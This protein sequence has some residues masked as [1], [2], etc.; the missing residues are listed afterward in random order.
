[1]KI[2]DYLEKLT[3]RALTIGILLSVAGCATTI[4]R[5]GA[6]AFSTGVIAARAQTKTAFDTVVTLTRETALDFAITQERLSEESLEAVP[7]AAAV[8]AWNG[9]FDPIEAYAQRLSSLIAADSTKS[10]E[11]SIG[12]LAKQFNTTS[13]KVK[14]NTGFGNAGQITAGS[15]SV[16]AEVAS[17]L[18]RARAEKEAMGVASKTDP[19][20]RLMFTALAE[21]IG[22]D[23]ISPGLRAT[24][25]ANWNQRVGEQKVKFLEAG[26][27]DKRR[28]VVK[29]YIELLNKR[30]AQD[31][32][33]AALRRTYLSL[34]DAHSALATGH[35]SD[36]GGAIDFI[37][38]ELKHARELKDQFTKTLTK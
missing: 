8:A 33:L 34:A 27:P 12:A 22:K 26:T 17:A 24:V 13:D 11:D 36:L 6:Q 1:M 28:P 4:D 20:I 37:S 14:D 25:R 30:D 38:A 18:L 15:A 23:N 31:E 2:I 5:G 19:A 35:T 3:P 29:D 10:V 32:L 9:V 7:N 21:A 16:F